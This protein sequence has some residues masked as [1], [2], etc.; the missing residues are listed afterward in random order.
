MQIQNKGIKIIKQ[1]IVEVTGVVCDSHSTS[2]SPSDI[3]RR[4]L[5]DKVAVGD[6]LL[7]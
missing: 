6:H 7:H 1:L 4:C 3:P 2:V 5:G